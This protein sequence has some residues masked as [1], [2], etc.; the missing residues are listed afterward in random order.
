MTITDYDIQF[1]TLNMELKPLMAL[2][3]KMRT[4]YIQSLHNMDSKTNQP[5]IDELNSLNTLI[6]DKMNQ[7]QIL[8]KKVAEEN[9]PLVTQKT[10]INK[11]NTILK[12]KKKINKMADMNDEMHNIKTNEKFD[13]NSNSTM[14]VFY[15]CSVII[16][17][18]ILIRGFYTN[19][20]TYGEQFVLLVIGISMIYYFGKYIKQYFYDNF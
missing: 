19:K 14:Y 12:E 17:L 6:L 3:E 7:L 1:D 10:I 2:Y 8:S 15:L 11:V 13:L 9:I 4:V 20:I 16:V 5:I 18:F